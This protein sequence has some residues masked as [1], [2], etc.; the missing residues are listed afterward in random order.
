MSGPEAE[1]IDAEIQ[2]PVVVWEGLI[3]A[4]LFRVV[5]IVDGPAPADATPDWYV[6]VERRDFDILARPSWVPVQRRHRWQEDVI[7]QY[8][9]I[10]EAALAAIGDRMA[11]ARE[12]A[13]G[14]K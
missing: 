14:K 6:R 5:V 12:K 3:E 9:I 7:E 10:L 1:V 13:K 2:P 11:K 8:A 4:T